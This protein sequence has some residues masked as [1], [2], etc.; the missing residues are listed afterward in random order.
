MK[1]EAEGREFAKIFLTVGQ[2]NFG[3]KIPILALLG[4]HVFDL[5]PNELIV[6]HRKMSRATIFNVT[7]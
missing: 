5:S 6:I 7:L 2:N 1:F 3:N 4:G